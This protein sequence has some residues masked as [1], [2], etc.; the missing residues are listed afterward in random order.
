MNII[1]EDVN[2]EIAVLKVKVAPEDYKQKVNASLEKYRKQAKVPGF[3]PGKI[4]MGMIQKQYGK[5]ILAEE[6]NKVVNDSLYSFI[7]EEKIEILGNPIPKKD[8]DVKG[9]FNNPA[10]FE[11]EYEIGLSP[12]I[13]VKDVLKGKFDY[14]KVKIDNDS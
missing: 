9:D 10:D 12:K 7:Q 2:A 8:V 6:L 14:V 5:A 4:P 3:R 11:F 13:D 1:R